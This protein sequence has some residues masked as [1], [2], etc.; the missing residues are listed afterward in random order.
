MVKFDSNSGVV[1]R[2]HCH[3]SCLTCSGEGIDDC[4]TCD[5]DVADVKTLT[6]VKNM[7]ECKSTH[8]WNKEEARCIAE[9]HAAGVAKGTSVGTLAMYVNDH[10]G[11]DF[12]FAGCNECNGPSEDNCL[13]CKT[14]WETHL[15]KNGTVICLCA[16][17]KFRKGI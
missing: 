13:S 8:Y 2:I 3:P 1:S 17:K 10:G 16:K 11:N 6:S 5:S 7:C 14:G 9:D 15:Q 12:C 4:L